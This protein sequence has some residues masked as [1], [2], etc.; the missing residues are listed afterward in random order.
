MSNTLA[1]DAGLV[2][3]IYE[4]SVLPEFWPHVIAA[5]TSVVDGRDALLSS[6]RANSVRMIS[7]SDRLSD[8]WRAVFERFP[9]ASNPRTERLLAARHAGFL[10]DYDVFSEE[11]IEAHPLYREVLVPRGYGRGA[12]TAIH[13][14]DGDAVVINIERGAAAGRFSPTEISLLNGLRPH[15]ARSAM[16]S[17]RLSFERAKTAVETLAGLG[18]AAAAVSRSG[19]PFLVNTEFE[20]EQAIWTTRG[21]NRIALHDR[22]ADGQL[23]E[24]LSAI[25]RTT[26]VR[27]LAL[28]AS[29]EAPPAVL[30]VVPIRRAAHDLF[31]HAAAILVL[32]KAS[33]GSAPSTPL[34]QALFDLTPAEARIAAFIATGRTVDEIAREDAKSVETVRNQLKSVLAKAGCRRQADLARLL[35]QLVPG[36]Y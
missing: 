5:L 28:V 9:G 24:A 1:L 23:R 16:I 34:L 31:G 17:A 25:D 32:T 29:G 6:V 18:L 35:V 8:T 36:Q 4:A 33:A 19:A 27:S 26:A 20:S 11:E 2:D 15:I 13:F 7:T 22:R 30:H 12:A 14:P 10:T 21:G 3:N